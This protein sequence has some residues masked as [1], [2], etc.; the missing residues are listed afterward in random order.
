[1]VKDPCIVFSQTI[2]GG[3]AGRISSA[4]LVRR[5]SKLKGLK[6]V[7]N[8]ITDPVVIDR[9]SIPKHV[10][11]IAEIGINHNG[12]I[13]IAKQLIDMAKAAGCDAVK[14][15]KRTID[16]VYTPELLA[17]PRESPWG[18]TQREQKE[19]LEFNKQQYDEIDVYCRNLNIDWFA[20]AWDIPSQRFLRQYNLKYNKIASAMATHKDFL[21]FVAS[22]RRPTFLSIG[23]CNWIEVE[24]A[25]TIFRTADCPVTLMHTVSEYPAREETLN[26]AMIPELRRRFDLAVG[27]SGHEPSVSPSV[28]AVML[29]AVAVERHITLDRAMYGSDQAASL[30][31]PGLETLCAQIRKVPPVVGD[32]QRRI[33]DKEFEVA[34]KLR[35]WQTLD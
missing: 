34:K 5:K 16:I 13:G 35:Y 23:M 6:R 15:Q 4:F 9:I 12:D 18:K 27:Y 32:G 33:T 30:E 21:E 31:R 25:V 14:F 17:S 1:M 26:L 10:F 3:G 22:E 20:S 24:R 8:S 11:I 28:M 2:L 29:G 19:G 7:N